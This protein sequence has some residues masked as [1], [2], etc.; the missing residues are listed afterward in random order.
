MRVLG[1][2]ALLAVLAL[3]AA[4]CGTD[5]SSTDAAEP[6][7][8][9][10]SPSQSAGSTRGGD[11]VGHEVLAILTATAAGGSVSPVAVRLDDPDD[12]LARAF[13]AQFR[14][15]AFSRTVRRGIQAAS[16][17]EGSSVYGAVVAVGCDVPQDVVVAELAGRVSIRAVPVEDPLPE[18]F[19]P[20]TT[21][22]LVRVAA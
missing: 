22:A 11:E 12:P 7:S 17:V 15:K 4:G 20:M 10:A 19:A 6:T 2:F 18:C 1:R 21:V 8:S 5:T 14:S 3:V 9:S 16:P 13:V